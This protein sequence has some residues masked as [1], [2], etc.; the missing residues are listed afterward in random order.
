[1]TTP[2]MVRC[3]KCSKLVIREDGTWT[4]DEEQ[5]DIHKISNEE[6]PVEAEY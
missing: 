4:C 6:C 1:M 5:K 2:E 3:K